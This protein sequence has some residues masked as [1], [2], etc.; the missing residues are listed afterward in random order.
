MGN[1]KLQLKKVQ[2]G[3]FKFPRFAY[4]TPSQ[5]KGMTFH[6]IEA[7]IKYEVLL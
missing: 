3:N 2:V 1:S 5:Y 7:L 4:M 6:R